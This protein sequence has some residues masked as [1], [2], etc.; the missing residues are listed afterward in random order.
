MTPRPGPGGQTRRPS[1][2]PLEMRGSAG[3]SL[4]IPLEKNSRLIDPSS[5]IGVVLER[6]VAAKTASDDG[7]QMRI[8][9]A[10]VPG[11]ALPGVRARRRAVEGCTKAGV[12]V[13]MRIVPMPRPTVALESTRD[14]WAKPVGQVSC[15]PHR[16]GG[17]P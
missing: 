13:A 9:R 8:W 1:R 2:S 14:G 3:A 4:S 7:P 11:E 10:E 16:N 5:L 15:H 12:P 6:P 17:D